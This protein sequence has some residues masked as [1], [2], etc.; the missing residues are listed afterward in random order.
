MS[1]WSRDTRT[2]GIQSYGIFPV[3]EAIRLVASPGGSLGSISMY[4]TGNS[5]KFMTSAPRTM[6]LFAS[7]FPYT[8]THPIAVVMIYAP[9]ELG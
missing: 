1:R 8:L 5:Y 3:L 7:P 4:M 6:Y 2:R 9:D